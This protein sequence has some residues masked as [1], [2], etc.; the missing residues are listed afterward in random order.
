MTT[1]AIFDAKNILIIG[2]SGFVGSHLCD[3]LVA[4]HKVICVDNF[5]TGPEENIAHLLEKTNFKFIKHDII[6]L[7]DL[8]AQPELADFKVSFQG[9]QV[10]YFVASPTSPRDYLA[11]PIETMLVNSV[12]LRNALDLAVR[13]KAQF[14][15]AS[16][17]AV[18]GDYQSNDPVTEEYRGAI[19]QFN[20][21][22]CYASGQ[23]FGEGLV[24]L[25]RRIYE[26]DTKIVR[27]FNAYGP[28]MRLDDGRMIPEM[29]RQASSGEDVVIYGNSD[30]VGSYFYITDLIKALTKVVT[31]SDAGPIN[32]GSE[33]QTPFSAIAEKI[34]TLSES[35]VRIIYRQP[36]DLVARQIR[37][38]ITKAKEKMGWFPVILLDEG[39]EATIKYLSA[40]GHILHPTN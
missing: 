27:I 36:D 39:L 21:R 20:D 40:Q 22:A 23:H 7:L 28:R 34:I 8:E 33:W 4:K 37:A 17:P 1:K 18:Y 6:N 26:I 14:V 19:D 2:G 15:Y 16:S 9:V 35:S 30:S 25:Y 12:G 31:I 38:D 24:A 11:H 29:I 5:L 13:Y 3:E 32:L 10:I